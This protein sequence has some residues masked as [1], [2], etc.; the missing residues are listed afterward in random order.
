MRRP[1]HGTLQCPA[2]STSATACVTDIADPDRHRPCALS[3]PALAHPARP[4]GCP[5][6]LLASEL[7]VVGGDLAV[8]QS[9]PLTVRLAIGDGSF[10]RHLELDGRESHAELFAVKHLG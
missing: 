10:R 3:L 8:A 1:P 2:C 9:S 7:S 6:R 4:P 5:R